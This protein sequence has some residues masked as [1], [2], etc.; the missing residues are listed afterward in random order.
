MSKNKS[1]TSVENTE[2]T[3]TDIEK[4]E[5]MLLRVTK[6]ITDSFNHCIDKL[7]GSLDQKL[8]TKIDYQNTELFNANKRIDVLEKQITDCQKE[9]SNLRDSV[10]SLLVRF[11]TLT[12][13]LD[14]MDQYSRSDN[15]IVYGIPLPADG[16][17]ETDVRQLVVDSLG[18]N[19]RNIDLKKEHI[20]VA[21]RLSA[22]RQA[23]HGQATPSPSSTVNLNRPPPIIVRFTQREIRNSILANRRQ[24]KGKPISISEQLTNRRSQLLRKTNELVAQHKVISTWSHDGRILIKDKSNRIITINN[25]T[26]L[27]QF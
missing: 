4:F 13:A 20:N 14:D 19:M 1:K 5:S 23:S 22:S 18:P 25:E 17:N 6:S 26:D 24:L 9:N 10:K 21:H 3:D 2:A 15:L 12:T 16:S 8:T 27:N 11:D 7:I